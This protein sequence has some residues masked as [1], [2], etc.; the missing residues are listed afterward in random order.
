MRSRSVQ[1]GR[2]RYGTRR[3]IRHDNPIKRES[4]GWQSRRGSRGHGDGAGF[5]RQVF[6]LQSF[7]SG[8]SPSINSPAHPQSLASPPSLPDYISLPPSNH[9]I[10]VH[11]V[12]FLPL[13]HQR[14]ILNWLTLPPRP[15]L[16]FP[17]ACFLASLHLLVVFELRCLST[18][19]N[20]DPLKLC[21]ATFPSL[22][23]SLPHVTCLDTHAATPNTTRNPVLLPVDRPSTSSPQAPTPSCPVAP[24]VRTSPSDPSPSSL[25]PPRPSR[26][27]YSPT[28]RPHPSTTPVC[29]PRTPVNSL[30]HH[31][32]SF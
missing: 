2:A 16:R 20:L 17:V 25:D 22:A 1:D 26:H 7:L 14:R 18:K 23:L 19:R 28:R 9:G 30:E 15:G 29:A 24:H 8:L 27:F 32:L 11:L 13:P 4:R 5:I 12:P 3:R 21:I 6:R 10:R 31:G